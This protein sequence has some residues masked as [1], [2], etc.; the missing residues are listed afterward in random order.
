[1]VVDHH[2]SHLKII[3]S[4]LSTL[5]YPLQY[6]VNLP[7]EFTEWAS[8]SLVTRDQ[9]LKENERLK[10]EHLLLSSRLQRFEV[11]ESE[12]N[13]LHRPCYMARSIY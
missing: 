3:R 8:I 2:H 1:M 5:V 10:Q 11:L 12:N 6:I 9:L 4:S 13:R 7:F